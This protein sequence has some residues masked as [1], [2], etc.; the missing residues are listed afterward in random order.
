MGRPASV[1]VSAP[2]M[3]R[4]IGLAERDAIEK[5]QRANDLVV[6]RP[7]TPFRNQMHLESADIFQP[8]TIRGT[9]EISAELRNGVDVGLMGRRRKIADRHV[10]DHATTQRADLGHLNFLSEMGCDTQILSDRRAFTRPRRSRRDH[11][12]VQSSPI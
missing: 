10:L 1:A 4:D 6:R 11:G 7:G 8:Q 2:V 9:T 12:F 3:N 5:A